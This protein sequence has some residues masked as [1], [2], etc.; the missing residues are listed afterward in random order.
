MITE[1]GTEVYVEKKVIVRS[2][3]VKNMLDD[4]AE[5]VIL[6]EIKEKTLKKIIKYLYHLEEGNSP[7]GTEKPI[8]DIDMKDVT[9]DWYAN[10]MDL[11]DEEVQDI[12]IAADYM[13]INCLRVLACAKMGS[14]I[15]GLSIPEFRKRFN[16]ANDFTPEEEAEPYDEAKLVKLAEEYEKEQAAKKE[17]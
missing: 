4:C 12:L 2:N 11:N 13:D 10:V 15:R 7:P 14:I 3:F 1:E 5:C 8:R 6:P 9:S 16:I 17:S